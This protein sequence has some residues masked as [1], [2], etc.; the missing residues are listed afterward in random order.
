[1]DMSGETHRRS[2]SE[3]TLQ[4]G[5]ASEHTDNTKSGQAGGRI[6]YRFMCGGKYDERAA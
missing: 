6:K 2:S 5:G 4:N 1:M 3:E